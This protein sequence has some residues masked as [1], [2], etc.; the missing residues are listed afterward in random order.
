[1][2]I[3][4]T[5]I[6]NSGINI[7]E[8]GMILCGKSGEMKYVRLE[9]FNFV[10]GC[11]GDP[12]RLVAV[13]KTNGFEDS[14]YGEF[15]SDNQVDVVIL[16]TKGDM[17]VRKYTE[18]KIEKLLVIEVLGVELKEKRDMA[19]PFPGEVNLPVGWSGRSEVTFSFVV[20]RTSELDEVDNKDVQSIVTGFRRDIRLDGL[21]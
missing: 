14:A 6:Y 16:V 7:P 20:G 15:M 4:N 19:H 9:H 13:S 8:L 17:L 5:G 1:M 18:L 12:D 21:I 2:N 3:Y 10:I 11:D